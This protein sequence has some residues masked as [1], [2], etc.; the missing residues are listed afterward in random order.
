MVT[1]TIEPDKVTGKKATE[2]IDTT[3]VNQVIENESHPDT[4]ISLHPPETL[5]EIEGGL[6]DIVD[7]L[8]ISH[9]EDFVQKPHSPGDNDGHTWCSGQAFECDQLATK[10]LLAGFFEIQCEADW[11]ALGLVYE[12]C[13]AN[14]KD[15]QVCYDESLIWGEEM[16]NYWPWSSDWRWCNDMDFD[17]PEEEHMCHWFVNECMFA[18]D[19]ISV[20][21]SNMADVFEEY[22]WFC[23]KGTQGCEDHMIC[24]LYTSPS[25]RDLSTSRMPS[26]A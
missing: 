26:S 19:D 17:E 5:Q 15:S 11:H 3:I 2:A 14:S 10:C 8:H 13:F 12:T 22:W 9:A 20:C 25:P 7:D 24:L 4:G 21:E 23:T 18:L 6:T 1:H 16:L